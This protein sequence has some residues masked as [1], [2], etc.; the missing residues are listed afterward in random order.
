MGVVELT[1]PDTEG[2][3]D[4]DLL[5]MDLMRVTDGIE[6]SDDT[7]LHIRTYGYSVSVELRS[8]TD[9]PY[10]AALVTTG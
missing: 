4:G 5:V 2:E 8:G 3:C 10:S 9:S 7:I 1:G 6:P